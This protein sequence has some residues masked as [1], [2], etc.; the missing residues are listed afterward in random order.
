MIETGVEGH[1]IAGPAAG[2]FAEFS[3]LLKQRR[4]ERRD[5]LMSALLDAEIDG[6]A[7]SEP[8]LL[9]FCF[10]LIVG[11]NDTTMNLL[12]NG[13]ALLDTHREAR[14]AVIDDPGLLPSAIEE[15]LRIEAPTQALPRRPT[16]DVELHGTRIPADA[17][18]LLSFGAANHDD[19][20]FENP[21]RFE[22][23]RQPNRHLSL[24]QGAH[25][26]MGASLA[27][28]EA[29]VAFEEFLGRFPDYTVDEEPGWVTSR[30]RARTHDWWRVSRGDGCRALP[31]RRDRCRGGRRS[32]ARGPH[33]SGRDALRSRPLPG[34]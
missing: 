13:L 5:D 29:R 8:E 34:S 1:D 17:R 6:A 32:R 31:T 22:I 7:L 24:G 33:A 2:I 30:W 14:A 21:G 19:R 26:C 28:M 25:F 15:M 12:G 11:G 3:E 16:R 4:R 23:E 18:V 20:V 9:G 27:R 10:L